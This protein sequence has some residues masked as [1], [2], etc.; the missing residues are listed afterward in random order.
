[1]LNRV[2]ADDVPADHTPQLSVAEN[3]PLGE[4]ARRRMSKWPA[5]GGVAVH[6]T[7]K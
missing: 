4:A 6:R 1:V 3:D 2:Y 5:L 7:P